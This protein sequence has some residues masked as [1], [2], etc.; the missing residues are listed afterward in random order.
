MVVTY[1]NDVMSCN[2]WYH[3]LMNLVE[4]WQSA[5]VYMFLCV[6]VALGFSV[7]IPKDDYKNTVTFEK[8]ED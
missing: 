1:N 5:V 3:E 4:G 8:M 6:T 2:P 7:F